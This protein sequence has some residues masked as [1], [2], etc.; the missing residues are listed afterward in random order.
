MVMR[1][2][3]G[4]LML[5][6]IGT[7]ASNRAAANEATAT[8]NATVSYFPADAARGKTLATACIACHG[9]ADMKLGNPPIRVPLLGGQRPEA[10]FASLRDYKSGARTSDIMAP[11]AAGLSL[12]DM[13]DLGAYLASSGPVMPGTHDEGS[14]AHQKVRRD[15]TACHGE[16]GMGVMP[17]V[18]VL[19]GQHEDYLVD[20][21][22]AYSS[23]AR[24]DP[25]MGPIAA[26][27]KPDE[28]AQLAA[29]FAK[30]KHLDLS[31]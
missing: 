12:Q 30:Q 31:K 10:I 7:I 13:R 24:K 18:P 6:A 16:S 3:A 4:L 22:N 25:T 5:A 1:A 2:I 29:Y 17:G 11:M 23:G 21:L 14:W 28:V 9:V 19:T 27:L 15:C 26:R 20:A 8:Q